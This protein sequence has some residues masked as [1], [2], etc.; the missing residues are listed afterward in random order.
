[1]RRFGS[2]L[3]AKVAGVTAVGVGSAV[4]A[5]PENVTTAMSDG[6]TDVKTVAAAGLIIVIAIVV[7]KYMK[8]G[9]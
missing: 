3:V 9:A 8:R 2:S 7:F 5:V 6:L 4:A 1:M